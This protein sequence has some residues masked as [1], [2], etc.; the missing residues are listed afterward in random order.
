MFDTPDGVFVPA[1]ALQSHTGKGNAPWCGGLIWMIPVSPFTLPGF[2]FLICTTA[3]SHGIL[4]GE[5][6]TL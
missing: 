3:C 2:F 4:L 5:N 1:H 6:H